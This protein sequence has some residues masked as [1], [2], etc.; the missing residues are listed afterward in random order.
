MP[1]TGGTFVESI[2]QKIYRRTGKIGLISSDIMSSLFRR[3]WYYKHYIFD[4]FVHGTKEPLG[5][6]GTCEYIPRMFANK[7]IVSVM[8]SPFDKWVSLY[9]YRWWER[10]PLT[11]PWSIR[12]KFPDYP[13]LSLKEYYSLENEDFM[14]LQLGN[15][16]R[17]DIGA[18]SWQFIRFYFRNPLEVYRAINKDNFKELTDS[19]LYDVCFMHQDKLNI[20][21]YN[22]LLSVGFESRNVIFVKKSKKILPQ[23]ST[24]MPNHDWEKELDQEDRERIIDQE[25]LLFRLFPEYLQAIEK[26]R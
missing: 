1:K 23:N 5:Q 22:L 10:H 13:K 24:R 3:R 15:D 8:R 6:H 14:K 17:T 11:H 25:W 12:K 20:E 18:L 9:Y 7:K 21:L 16:Y 19:T 26:L 4:C 2:F